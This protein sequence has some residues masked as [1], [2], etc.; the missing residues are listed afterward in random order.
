MLEYQNSFFLL[1]RVQLTNEARLCIRGQTKRESEQ[2]EECANALVKAAV[3]RH[4]FRKI[5]DS[6]L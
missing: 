3:V 5:G 1:N 2:R 4:I 6:N